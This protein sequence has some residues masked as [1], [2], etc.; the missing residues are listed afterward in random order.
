MKPILVI[1]I[2][3]IIPLIGFSQANK[4]KQKSTKNTTQLIDSL[5][6]TKADYEL[7]RETLSKDTT[8]CHHLDEIIAKGDTNAIQLKTLLHT[9]Y[10]L[11]LVS[12][13]LSDQDINLM[14]FGFYE[15]QKIIRKFR[16][17]D[18]SLDKVKYEN[19][20]LLLK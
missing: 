5:N 11:R 3:M 8:F 10:E 17:L 4:K 15:S 18:N 20:S 1:S 13:K 14:I 7:M 16:E 12:T 2:L 9:P 6:Y 19:D